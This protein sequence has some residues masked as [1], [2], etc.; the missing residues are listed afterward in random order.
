MSPTAGGAEAGLENGT[1]K[2]KKKKKI[3]EA[4]ANMEI[5]RKLPFSFGSP[6]RVIPS[7]FHC[8]P[9]LLLSS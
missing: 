7:R 6:L 5:S 8:V 1:T 9:N 4:Q 3:T 2:K